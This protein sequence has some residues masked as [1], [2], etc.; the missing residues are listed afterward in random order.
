MII[1]LVLSGEGHPR[2][3]VCLQGDLAINNN[4]RP[5]ALTFP[6]RL[7]YHKLTTNLNMHST[8]LL[9]FGNK[10]ISAYSALL[11]VR[12]VVKSAECTCYIAYP[13]DGCFSP[14]IIFY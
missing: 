6:Y 8:A 7:C 3:P 12:F 10:C 13:Y 14:V 2:T 1:F 11:C 5:L 9:P 4:S